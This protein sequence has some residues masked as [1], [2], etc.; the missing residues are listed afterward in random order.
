MSKVSLSAVGIQTLQDNLYALSEAELFAEAA[1][2][3]ADFVAWVDAKIALTS[4]Q[5]TWLQ[6]IDPLF[7]EYL[8]IKT[9]IALRNKLDLKVDLPSAA[10]DGKWFQDKDAIAPT[11]RANGKIEATGTFRLKLGYETT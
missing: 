5:L 3:K 2:V 1:A 6:G 7:T 11:Y 9:C 8:G 4:S 10:G